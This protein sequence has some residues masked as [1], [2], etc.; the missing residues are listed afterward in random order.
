MTLTKISLQ[1]LRQSLK[2]EVGAR[3]L[4]SREDLAKD[5]RICAR[6]LYHYKAAMEQLKKGNIVRALNHK[7]LMLEGHATRMRLREVC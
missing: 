4:R 1:A 6:V 5:R 3:S 2:W 7:K